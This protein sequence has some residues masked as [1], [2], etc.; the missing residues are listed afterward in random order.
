MWK[1]LRIL[2]VALVL[3]VIF[4]FD[5][6]AGDLRYNFGD[7]TIKH[8]NVV[9]VEI[10]FN[11]ACA[12]PRSGGFPCGSGT[13]T[14]Y[15]LTGPTSGL[16]NVATSNFA[17]AANGTST[18]T[19]T[20]ADASHNGIF[21]PATV[22][23][24]GLSPQNFTYKPLQ[25]GTYNISTT[26]SGTLTNPAAI[27]LTVP[28]LLGGYPGLTTPWGQNN[29]ATLTTGV[30]GGPF[31][32]ADAASLKEGTAAN[33]HGAIINY[34]D[35]ANTQ[36]V[37]SIFIKQSVGTRNIDVELD[38]CTGFTAAFGATFNPSNG[39]VVG[40]FAFG[41]GVVASTSTPVS[42]GSGW[43]LEQVTGTVGNFTNICT[44]I[45]MNNGVGNNYTGD[46]TSTVL[47]SRA[48]VE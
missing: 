34:T 26:N 38:E 47:L 46:G 7:W 11:E 19:I 37:V 21:N 18:A 45:F 22:N 36:R 29:D 35:T 40:S 43:W 15:T 5:F 14:S 12:L 42:I 4:S 3:F 20:P 32:A 41:G 27:S 39:N 24:S 13:A 28:N 31:G 48:S 33:F 23:L 6:I 9:P 25:T 44:Q 30:A 17:V 10:R 2:L 16:I 8:W 1:I